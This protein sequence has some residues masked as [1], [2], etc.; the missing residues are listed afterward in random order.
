MCREGRIFRS[1][2]G[3]LELT[4]APVGYQLREDSAVSQR[5]YELVYR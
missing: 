4:V 2:L 1:S 5:V 3:S